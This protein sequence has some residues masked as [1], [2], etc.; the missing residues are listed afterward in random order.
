MRVSEGARA[1][2]FTRVD[3]LVMDVE[4]YERR[5][6]DDIINSVDCARVSL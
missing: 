4:G 6:I 5:I 3:L 1:C 2:N